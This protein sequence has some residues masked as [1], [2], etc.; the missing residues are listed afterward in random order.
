VWPSFEDVYIKDMA[1]CPP[2]SRETVVFV[3]YLA[4]VPDLDFGE[5]RKLPGR[6]NVHSHVGYAIDLPPPAQSPSGAVLTP[7]R[8]P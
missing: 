3:Q 1:F 5:K 7:S 8:H 6:I 4:Q 2:L